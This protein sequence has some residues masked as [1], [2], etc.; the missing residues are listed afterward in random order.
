MSASVC[1]SCKEA[2]VGK[3]VTALDKDWHPDHFACAHCKKPI[4]GGS[5]HTKDGKPYCVEDYARLYMAKCYACKEPIH[6]KVVKAQD[7]T[8]HEEHWCCTGCRKPLGAASFME[9]EGKPYC[10]PCNTR[11]FAPI[12]SGCHEPI[13]GKVVMAMEK[14]WHPECFKCD[15]CSKAIPSDAKF[16]VTNEKAFCSN[17]K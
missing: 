16:K 15:K 12:C 1:F 3:I 2:I 5:F 9:K 17:C 4:S 8:W 6:D 11:L 10:L 7:K 13:A 14:K